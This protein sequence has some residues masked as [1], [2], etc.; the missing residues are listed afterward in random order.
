MLFFCIGGGPAEGQTADAGWEV[1]V[2]LDNSRHE[3]R[4]VRGL[5]FRGPTGSLHAPALGPRVLG[6][7]QDRD[8][9]AEWPG[10]GSMAPS[11]GSMVP[12]GGLRES[13]RG[14]PTGDR[15]DGVLFDRTE[16]P[17]ARGTEWRLPG[18]EVPAWTVLLRDVGETVL[19]MTP[20]L[21]LPLLPRRID[22]RNQRVLWTFHHDLEGDVDWVLAMGLVGGSEGV[23]W[24]GFWR[25]HEGVDPGDI[26]E[27]LD[28]APWKLMR[29]VIR[30]YRD[31]DSWTPKRALTSSLASI[32]YNLVEGGSIEI[33][34][35]LD[36]TP[37][38]RL[39]AWVRPST[40]SYPLNG[41]AGVTFDRWPVQWGVDAYRKL[42][43]ANQWEPAETKKGNSLSAFL[44]G[45]DNGHYFTSS[46]ASLW[47]ER[48]HGMMTWR[49][50]IFSESDRTATVRVDHSVF[51]RDSSD[52]RPG[53]EAEDG[54]SFGIRGV[55]ERQWGL[56]T[57]EGVVMTR[58]WFGTAGGDHTF[59]SIGGSADAVRTWGWWA[60]G[61]RVAGGRV[62]GNAPIQR[63]FFLGGAT[64][65]RGFDPAAAQGPV[66]AFSRLELGFGPPAARLMAFGDAGWAGEAGAL[67]HLASVGLG[68]SFAEGFFRLDAAKPVSGGSGLKLYLTGNG[69][70]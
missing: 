53:L 1:R 34:V 26:D 57:S 2:L 37:T 51:P 48:Q 69:L 40:T 31:R 35:W 11:P 8:M 50:E 58:V 18:A 27:A 61:V 46:G 54:D 15:I 64:T 55:A 65:M 66:V 9:V 41:G 14:D 12:S 5:F 45:G 62:L 4:R 24:E 22:V 13:Q 44:Y 28:R 59:T 38:A 7:L 39:R 33:P 60:A 25:T 68:I 47:T 23:Y 20:P 10:F 3:T 42:R 32:R 63:E 43:D 52:V 30:A 36:L 29:H 70:L 21:R 16:F 6:F 17:L 67:E 49:V 19:S 56:E